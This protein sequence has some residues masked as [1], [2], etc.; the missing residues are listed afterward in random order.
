ML[1]GFSYYFLILFFITSSGR[2][3]LSLCFYP[4]LSPPPTTPPH[5]RRVC[6]YINERPEALLGTGTGVKE[7]DDDNT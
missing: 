3:P 7:R 6:V 4:L 1:L 2:F 5:L